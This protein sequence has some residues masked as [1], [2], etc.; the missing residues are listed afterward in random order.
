MG[1][2]SALS[3]VLYCVLG[4][5]LTLLSTFVGERSALA[6]YPDIMGCESGCTVVA[7]GW[8]LTF[9]RDYLGISVVNTADIMEVWFAAD[10][11]IWHP[12][13]FNVVVWSL[14]SFV[15]HI[16]FRRLYGAQP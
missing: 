7:T 3:L 9:V 16:G 14:A 6:V 10:R 12:F 2:K 4:V 15:A 5:I 1:V 8:P 13:V 11:L